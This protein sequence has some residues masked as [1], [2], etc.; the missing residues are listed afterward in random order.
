M[1]MEIKFTNIL[2]LFLTE[3]Y[4]IISFLNFLI[5]KIKIKKEPLSVYEISGSGDN[6]SLA[7]RC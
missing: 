6:N 7:S 1:A 4:R 5:L 2:I 3:K